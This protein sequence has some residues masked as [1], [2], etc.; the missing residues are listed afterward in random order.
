MF[1]IVICCYFSLPNVRYKQ[2]HCGW[3]CQ[4]SDLQNIVFLAEWIWKL[5]ISWGVQVLNNFNLNLVSI[6]SERSQ[7]SSHDLS[8]QPKYNS[9]E[10]KI[11]T[12]I[13]NREYLWFICGLQAK[14]LLDLAVEK[15]RDSDRDSVTTKR[16]PG[17]VKHQAP[18][19]VSLGILTLAMPNPTK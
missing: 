17:F 16:K 10:M 4:K 6:W 9:L 3:Q 2:M 19:F 13:T 12:V 5:K 8:Q 1:I 7:R 14:K 15:D 11:N 18:G